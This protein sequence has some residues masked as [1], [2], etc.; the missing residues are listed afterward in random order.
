MS[1]PVTV[2]VCPT[3]CRC[4]CPRSCGHVWAGE[5]EIRDSRGRVCGSS[6]ACARCGMSA[7]EHDARVLP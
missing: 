7:M 6:L 3:G 4:D 2:F 1:D 5:R